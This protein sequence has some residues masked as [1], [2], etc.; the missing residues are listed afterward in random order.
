MEEMKYPIKVWQ[1]IAYY[2]QKL[3]ISDCSEDEFKSNVELLKKLLQNTQVR[4][5]EGKRIASSFWEVGLATLLQS[6]YEIDAVNK[7]EEFYEKIEDM[8]D[9][10]VKKHYFIW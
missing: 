4:L 5:N 2:V 7:K 6:I 10:G 3:N 8:Q 1:E 9:V